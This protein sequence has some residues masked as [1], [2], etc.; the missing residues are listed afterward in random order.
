M[1]T[2]HASA[3]TSPP[4]PPIPVAPASSR[5]GSAGGLTLFMALA[6]VCWMDRFIVGALVTP[7]KNQLSLTDE[8]V[9][10]LQVTFTLAFVIA[11]PV[12]GYLGDRFRRK[13]ILFGGIIL[14]SFASLGSGFTAAL[15]PLLAWRA[16][17]GVGEAS[18]H[19]LSPSWV[20]D[21]FKSNIRN[22]IF[23][24]FNSTS[25][26][27]ATLGVAIGGFIAAKHGWQAA[28]FW[29]G[30]PGFVL[31]FLFLSIR[32]PRV[33]ANDGHPANTLI[34]PTLR[35]SL[36]IF[37]LPNYLLYIFG[38]LF[39]MLAIGGLNLWGPAYFHRVY[40]LSNLA[41]TGF[42]GLGYTVTGLP[43]AYLGGFLGSYFQ[44][45]TRSAYAF[46]MT[47]AMLLVTPVVIVALIT[48]NESLFRILI[49]TEM[50]LFGLCS[51]TVTTLV[52]ETVPLSLR[53]SGISGMNVVSGGIG[54]I[55]SAELLGI[56]SDHYG[57]RAAL[58]IVPASTFAA[59]AI[60][61]YLGW[62]QRNGT[63]PE[64]TLLTSPAS[65]SE[66]LA[67]HLEEEI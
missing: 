52:F 28:F 30:L 24:L 36:S 57:L 16:L 23:S 10:R 34:R 33:G 50:F 29:T 13:W 15:A 14:W 49:W 40:H 41:A 5:L 27:G 19:S 56:V 54:G 64:E 18:F 21:I 8:Q 1:D 42:F 67:A 43:G 22:I 55:L 9:G 48:P 53:N 38:Y 60:W 65:N 59:A 26:I 3:K 12:F 63:E 46:L 45:R 47:V 11:A 25:K 62:R 32:E 31:A 44:R 17:V 4:T 61:G 2:V 35:Q 20:A 6:L 66:V 51:A 39:Y 37:T 7:I 58:F